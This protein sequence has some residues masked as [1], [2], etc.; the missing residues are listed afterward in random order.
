MKKSNCFRLKRSVSAFLILLS[1][2]VLLAQNLRQPIPQ[3]R[4]FKV[5]P[6]RDLDLYHPTTQ[7]WSTELDFRASSNDF[8]VQGS[9]LVP[10]YGFGNGPSDRGGFVEVD[11]VADDD[12]Q[13]SVSVGFVHRWVGPEQNRLFG[14]N[15]FGDFTRLKDDSSFSQW[16]GGFDVKDKHGFALSANYYFA[17]DRRVQTGPSITGPGGFQIAP[18][19]VQRVG[20]V[21]TTSDPELIARQHEIT[22]RQI[23][24]TTGGQLVSADAVFS[25]PQLARFLEGRSGGDVKLSWDL[26]RISENILPTTVYGGLEY[27][28][29]GSA[30]LDQE[31]HAIAG[32]VTHPFRGVQLGA[33]YRGDDSRFQSH[34]LVTAG[35]NL[36]TDVNFLDVRRWP[37]ILG[38]AF[39]RHDQMRVTG[40]TGYFATSLFDHT[41]RRS[42]VT[43]GQTDLIQTGV[44]ETRQAGV[45]QPAPDG[46]QEL[47][48]NFYEDVIFVNNGGA[49]GNGILAGAAGAVGTAENP[50]NT[51]QDGVAQ[52]AA[53]LN[54]QGMI[55]VQ[56]TGTVYAETAQV[57]FGAGAGVTDVYFLSSNK[58]LVTGCGV[59]GGNTGLARIDGSLDIRGGAGGSVNYAA[60]EGFDIRGDTGG[61][62]VN[63]EDVGEFIL[64]CNRLSGNLLGASV[65][66][67]DGSTGNIAQIYDNVFGADG[68]ITTAAISVD[69]DNASGGVADITDN[70]ID[71][72]GSG[73][74]VAAQNGSSYTANVWENNIGSATPANGITNARVQLNSASGS[75]ATGNVTNNIIRNAAIDGIRLTSNGSTGDDFNVGSAAAV[76]PATATVN[77]LPNSLINAPGTTFPGVA[78]SYPGFASPAATAPAANVI[79]AT[80]TAIAGTAS[81]GATGVDVDI[82]GND[83]GTN[84]ATTAP[85]G[86]GI[87]YATSDTTTS[88]DV[89]IQSNNIDSAD[90]QGMTLAATTGATANYVVESNTIDDVQQTGAATTQDAINMT[91]DQ[92]VQA[93]I[94]VAQNVIGQQGAALAAGAPATSTSSLSGRG[95]NITSTDAGTVSN[96]TVDQ[97][98]IVG[99]A[100]G[101]LVSS[102]QTTGDV[103]AIT[104]NQLDGITSTTAGLGDGIAY[105]ANAAAPAGPVNISGNRVGMRSTSG[106]T[107]TGAGTAPAV[108]IIAVSTNGATSDV[109]IQNNFV[110]DSNRGIA[111]ASFNAVEDNY[112]IA[113]N[114]V[115][116][117]TGIN[118]GIGDLTGTG[119]IFDIQSAAR[120]TGNSATVEAD[121]NTVSGVG[122]ADG[123][124][125]IFVLSGSLSRVNLVSVDNNVVNDVNAGSGITIFGRQQG[126]I[127][128]EATVRQ[129][130]IGGGGVGTYTTAGGFS[131]TASGPS[132]ANASGPAVHGIDIIAGAN[133]S[134]DLAS[135]DNNIVV[136]QDGIGINIRA[137][138]NGDIDLG[139]VAQNL[140]DG[141][142]SAPDTALNDEIGNSGINI[143]AETNIIRGNAALTGQTATFGTLATGTITNAVNITENIVRDVTS[144]GLLV[145]AGREG[146]LAYGE[147][148]NNEIS[149]VGEGIVVQSN[150]RSGFDDRIAGNPNT[151]DLGYNGNATLSGGDIHNNT[152]TD[153]EGA[154]ITIAALDANTVTT[155]TNIRNNTINGYGGLV[156]DAGG[157]QVRSSIEYG[158]QSTAAQTANGVPTANGGAGTMP[159]T[160]VNITGDGIH[161]NTITDS[162]TAGLTGLIVGFTGEADHGIFLTANAGAF[163]G[164]LDFSSGGGNQLTSPT[165]NRIRF[166]VDPTTAGVNGGV[167]D[168]DIRL[169]S[170][171]TAAGFKAS[172]F[173]QLEDAPGFADETMQGLIYAGTVGLAPT[174]AASYTAEGNGGIRL[175]QNRFGS[176]AEF[177]AGVA[178]GTVVTAADPM[179]RANHAGLEFFLVE[180]TNGTAVVTSAN[181]AN[182]LAVGEFSGTAAGATNANVS[183]YDAGPGGGGRNN[184]AAIGLTG[185]NPQNGI[186]GGVVFWTTSDNAGT[187]VNASHG[188]GGITTSGN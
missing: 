177:G 148:A 54:G 24:R 127:V 160:L 131:A 111:V 165:I 18:G 66:Y 69:Y 178:A 121:N 141:D 158:E 88:S 70:T 183:F 173:A 100:E 134:I 12:G 68:P 144:T 146:A 110:E 30:G 128:G 125:G 43:L 120:P 4:D 2:N 179:L 79:D 50:V 109:S 34:W 114:T 182:S 61:A 185:S 1:G 5:V 7:A 62:G 59:F 27:F 65:S 122:G 108:G 23:V 166:A 92:G 37:Q 140:V 104:G 118:D 169:D 156:G 132:G 90:T 117:P 16:G 29:A 93:T 3:L 152:I 19:A 77:P 85:V 53:Q 135:V 60:V 123:A 82:I 130:F 184:V 180:A 159:T 22:C 73:V 95:V 157:I 41:D 76:T 57:G 136:E 170:N 48:V 164:T 11:V 39:T 138:T 174:D 81:A 71:N 113:N 161:N 14:L 94:R 151:L 153:A 9:G 44:V 42:G 84:A 126:E 26:P 176:V 124:N 72:S 97:N 102:I 15:V 155:V 36:E 38:N 167:F 172:A 163:D 133:S 162:Y 116:D 150:S 52:L 10:L 147:I 6:N 46:T 175:E 89:L 49:V 13:E 154:G 32:V 63:V 129:N 115:G 107:F 86:T 105:E 188:S 80:T 106:A 75:T 87:A 98:Q 25:S 96:V 91:A 33:E 51:I 56:E 58:P 78:G 99:G 40:D 31:L 21:T 67:T 137:L 145:S 8:E 74:L 55:Y 64:R 112:V 103:V 139:Q 142:G 47:F 28:E 171:S 20:G 181:P 17:G 186:D 187:P 83:I 35:I 149:R 143:V 45:S 101:I 168:N 119:I